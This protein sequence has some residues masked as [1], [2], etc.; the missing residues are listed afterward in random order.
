MG[1]I[2]HPSIPLALAMG[3][4]A[5]LCPRVWIEIPNTFQA[6]LPRSAA[7]KGSSLLKYTRTVIIFF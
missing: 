7:H 6:M 3:A 1:S 2:D 4:D 5:S